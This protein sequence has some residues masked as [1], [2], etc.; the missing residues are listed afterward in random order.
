MV[1]VAVLD[2]R[3]ARPLTSREIGKVLSGI[4]GGVVAVNPR[5][6]QHVAG[7][8]EAVLRKEDAR[9][10]GH[11]YRNDVIAGL[12][13]CPSWAVAFSATVS[14]LRGWCEHSDVQTALRWISENV[15]LI[16]SPTS[17]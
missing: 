4:L 5:A 17:N 7:V 13:I 10:I 3:E 14:G 6:R 9:S 1:A 16:C 8:V 11:T 12:D 2:P 15:G